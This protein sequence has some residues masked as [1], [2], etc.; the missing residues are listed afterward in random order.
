M[1]HPL[2]TLSNN[3]RG[4][5]Y[6]TMSI[7]FDDEAAKSTITRRILMLCDRWS[8]WS[9]G[10]AVIN[11]MLALGLCSYGA[12]EIYRSVN[13][14]TCLPGYFSSAITSSTQEGSGDRGM[15]QPS[16]GP[17][18]CAYTC[19]QLLVNIGNSER[20]GHCL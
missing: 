7:E 4:R 18:A 6:S 8:D 17:W 12:V 11:Q 15:S 2:I 13:Y 1:D 3:D 20:K 9:S 14:S 10:R 16:R 5:V 19:A